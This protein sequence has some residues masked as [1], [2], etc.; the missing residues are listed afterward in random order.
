MRK[1]LPYSPY[2]SPFRM[3]AT[4]RYVLLRADVTR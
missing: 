1:G 2:G 3:S 4:G